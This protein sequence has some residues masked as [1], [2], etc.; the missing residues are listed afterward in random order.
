MRWIAIVPMRAL[1]SAKSRLRTATADS[2]AHERLVRAIRTD[3]LA[4]LSAADHVAR[5]VLTVDQPIEFTGLS[6][7]IYVQQTAGLNAA[8]SEAQSWAAR[9]WPG[10]G[11]AAI[12]GDLPSAHSADLDQ[13]LRAA[14]Q[15]DRAYVADADATGTTML[16][17]LPGVVLSPG[18]G[19]D[20]A[21][22]H[23]RDAVALDVAAGL[24]L[25]VD[26]PLDLRAAQSLGLGPATAAL[27]ATEDLR[28]DRTPS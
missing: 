11:I 5:V 18:F 19:L 24:R 2:Q 14:E 7:E 9:R 10:H 21:R 6:Y 17:A 3:T 13:A 28:L 16:T 25:D 12:V 1:P 8:I 23:S 26:T 15:H 22:I 27:L 4:A 20:S